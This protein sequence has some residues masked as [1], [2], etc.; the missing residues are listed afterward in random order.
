MTK[1][2]LTML[3]AASVALC[4]QET[5]AKKADVSRDGKPDTKL[6]KLVE[7]IASQHHGKVAFFAKNLKTGA[8]VGVNPD[9]VVKTASTIKLAALIEGFYQ[10]K[11]GKKNLADKVTLRKEDQ[12]GGS[13]TFPFLRAP[14]DLTLED[15]LTFMVIYSD[16][17]GTNLAI[18]QFGLK[19]INERIASMGLKNTY[20]YKKV[21]K[22]AEGPMPSDQK[23]YGLGKTTPREIGEMMESIDRCD[24][25]DPEL[26]K[27][28]LDILKKQQY[29]EAIPR[30][31]ETSDTSEVPSA[32]ANKTGAL[33]ALRADVALVYTK[34]GKIL[35][36]AYAYENKDQR[37][38]P[39]NEAYI[40]IAKLAKV[41][42]D[43]WAPKGLQPEEEKDAK[44]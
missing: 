32:I 7:D 22:P 11:A 16:N 20:F 3:L 12:V 41:I 25:G 18:D 24:L 40:T 29:R 9:E 26:C 36:S 33:D 5:S 42:V 21:F 27:K 35:I 23:T 37:W 28:M 39:D 30:Y 8:T 1:K 19:N 4:A 14:I 34:N 6:Q 17:T 10:I 44:K 43:T 15:V 2:V 13:G 31:I 38:N